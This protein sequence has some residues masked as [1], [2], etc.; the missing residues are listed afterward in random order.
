MSK[1]IVAI[2]GGENG[3]INSK[4]EQKP[5]ETKEIDQ[6]IVRLSGKA[7]PKLLFLAHSQIP[8]GEAAE[9]N[10]YN[11]VKNIYENFGCEVKWLKISELKEDIKKAKDYVEWA[12]IIYEG[13]GATDYMIKFWKETGFDRVLKDAW[14]SGKVM[15]GVSA[16]AICWFNSG[17]TDNPEYIDKEFN[18]VD[19]L[20]FIDVYFT[21]HIQILGKLDRVRTS[22]KYIDKVGISL[23]NC[24]AIE[25]IDNEYKIIKS[26][27]SDESFKPYAL[28][29]YW[30]DGE[31]FEE[32]LNNINDY[33]SIDDL[34]SKNINS[35]TLN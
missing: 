8:F 1:K 20:N 33:N 7:N 23:S 32:E 19:A 11:V 9:E 22:L 3:R 6:E 12:D 16:G 31:L 29:T 17:F 25:I 35:R 10:Y 21:P 15:C 13:G 28:K 27:P 34:L 26:K 14:E 18:K 30:K 24:A 5:Y 2:G 4:G